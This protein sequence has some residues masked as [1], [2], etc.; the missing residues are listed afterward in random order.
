MKHEVKRYNTKAKKKIP[1]KSAIHSLPLNVSSLSLAYQLTQ[2]VSRIGFDWP[3]ID[4]VLEKWEEEIKEFKQAYSLKNRKKMGEEIGDLLFVLVNLS[5]VLRINPDTALRK[6]ILKFI[7][8]FQ[9][10]EKSL[11]KKGLSLRQSNLIEMDQL[12]EEAKAK[13]RGRS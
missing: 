10:I 4:G 5:R 9:Y 6:T 11:Y 1:L 13:E 3:T 8:R 12:W 7:A 2:K